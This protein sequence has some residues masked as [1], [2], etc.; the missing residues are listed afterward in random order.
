MAASAVLVLWQSDA[1]LS[2]DKPRLQNELADLQFAVAEE[3]ASN[4]AEAE[5]L[6][7]AEADRRAAQEDAKADAAERAARRR[8]KSERC[9]YCREE[10]KP[11]AAKCK[12]CGEILDDDLRTERERAARPRR[13]SPLLAALLSWVWPGL[14]HVYKGEVAAGFLWWFA[15]CVGYLMCILPGVVLHWVCIFAAASGSDY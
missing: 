1:Q 13:F 5:S 6:R 10:V 8:P 3:R 9:P 15:V 4:A 12:H 7:R 14:G 2:A 11:Y